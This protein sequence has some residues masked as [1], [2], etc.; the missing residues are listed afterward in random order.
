MFSWLLSVFNKRPVNA[1]T[2]TPA[3]K[4]PYQKGTMDSLQ[5]TPAE[6][7]AGEIAEIKEFHFHVYWFIKD[8]K[9]E[10]IALAL[11]DRILALNA[12]GYFVAK[13]LESINHYPM[14]PHP[15]ASYEVW[16]PAEH[17]A[18]AYSWFTLNRPAE[19]TILLHPLTRLERKDHSYRAVFLGGP[20]AI[21]I[22]LDFLSE[23]A[24][25]LPL[26]YPEL[27]LGYSAPE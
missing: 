25:K 16:V 21:P 18:R 14:G 7:A 20:P 26:Q 6:I 23:L 11:R 13:P 2:Y 15:I 9:T 3:S 12:S 10:A 4:A 8:K 19:L 22:K 5:L 24:E 17:F 27:G 1:I